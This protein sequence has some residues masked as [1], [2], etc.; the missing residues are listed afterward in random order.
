MKKKPGISYR[1]LAKRADAPPPVEPVAPRE[2]TPPAAL[3]AVPAPAGGTEPVVAPAVE[4]ERDVIPAV[5]VEAAAAAEF[6]PADEAIEAPDTESPDLARQYLV[7]RVGREWFALALDSADEAL[8]FGE[9][10]PLPEMG[11]TMLG[12]F[13]LRGALVPLF[14]PAGPL[15]IPLAS[16]GAAVVFT[17]P[18]GR[19]AIAVD[20]V[21][22]V[23]A[24]R[25]SE[26]LRAPVDTADDVLIGVVRR[27]RE[28]VGV[29]D[30]AALVAACRAEPVLETV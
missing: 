27:G 15:G 6:A 23:M 22:D 14:T 19:V 1:D 24:I 16:G 13:S 7:V 25:P 10:H 18:G 8:D 26:L 11:E 5:E 20:D 2:R 21:D 29:L 17:V 28:L 9:L 30:A 3:E 12:V 4:I